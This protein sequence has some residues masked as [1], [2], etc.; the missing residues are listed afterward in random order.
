[1]FS[2][3]DNPGDR[4]LVVANHQNNL[5]PMKQNSLTL[6]YTF[7][8]CD[9]GNLDRNYFLRVLEQ[10]ILDPRPITR[11][12]VLVLD[13]TANKVGRVL[14]NNLRDPDFPSAN[15]DNFITRSNVGLLEVNSG[16]WIIPRHQGVTRVF[17]VLRDVPDYDID[18][19]KN[20]IQGTF[21]VNF[22]QFI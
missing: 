8:Q 2:A 13:Q 14:M 18:S 9:L 12:Q 7:V 16:G 20:N 22:K 10:V 5:Y 1:M 6:N 11:V 19:I 15:P 3:G 4:L 17:V 21:Q